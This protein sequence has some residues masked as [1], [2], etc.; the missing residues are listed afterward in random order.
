LNSVTPATDIITS[1]PAVPIH[2]LS[3]FRAC[4]FQESIPCH[5]VR[6]QTLLTEPATSAEHNQVKSEN[7]DVPIM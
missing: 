7:Y 1:I 2:L 6:G 4:S 3:L 5:S